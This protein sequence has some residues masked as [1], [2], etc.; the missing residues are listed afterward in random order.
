MGGLVG[1]QPPVELRV[2]GLGF[3]EIAQPYPAEHTFN[4]DFIV[5]V[6][7]INKAAD[8]ETASEPRFCGLGRLCNLLT[9]SVRQ[10]LGIGGQR[11]PQLELP[12]LSLR[13]S[14]VEGLTEALSGRWPLRMGSPRIS[15]TNSRDAPLSSDEG[16]Q[17]VS[18]QDLGP[19]A[20]DFGQ[21]SQPLRDVFG[22]ARMQILRGQYG[23]WLLRNNPENPGN[24]EEFTF[25]GW[26][27]EDDEEDEDSLEG[28]VY[29]YEADEDSFGGMDENDLPTPGF[30]MG[31]QLQQREPGSGDDEERMWEEAAS[32]ENAWMEAP[33]VE[34]VD[35]EELRANL[36][37][38]RYNL[39]VRCVQALLHDAEGNA[40]IRIMAIV[41][42][43]W[44]LYSP[45]DFEEAMANGRPLPP[46]PRDRQDII[47]L[48]LEQ[49]R[50]I[51]TLP[52]TNRDNP[53]SGTFRS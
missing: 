38:R 22:P 13:G 52:G 18:Q 33:V 34:L 43:G 2:A 30:R 37:D 36:L 17:Q 40:D 42:R 50:P 47:D 15:E 28:M 35:P 32:R 41:D 6:Q 53:Q 45:V 39:Y 24:D 46:C 20:F 1:S 23:N 26:T 19:E 16:S 29:D 44:G 5:D 8:P 25:H 9:N 48:A 4:D 27:E 3:D 11:R 10:L 31:E 12:P 49:G 51:D 14:P 21:P 7:L